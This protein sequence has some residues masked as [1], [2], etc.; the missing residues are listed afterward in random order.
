MKVGTYI[1]YKY[2]DTTIKVDLVYLLNIKLI[3][4]C[5]LTYDSQVIATSKIF[6]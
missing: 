4:L 3:W 6:M 5:K 1:T 2:L